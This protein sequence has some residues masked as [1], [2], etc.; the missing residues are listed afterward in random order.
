MNRKHSSYFHVRVSGGF[1][2]YWVYKSR[3]SLA[4]SLLI[5]PFSSTSKI[6]SEIFP[7]YFLRCSCGLSFPVCG[8][9]V[10]IYI[11]SIVEY[12]IY[13]YI[14][15]LTVPGSKNGLGDASVTALIHLP[16]H[17]LIIGKCWLQFPRDR[18]SF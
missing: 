15:Y 2:S 3:V 9:V 17:N 13:I 7:F 6:F 4:S 14:I 16:G 11:S 18:S 10:S 1:R 12:L 8:E 5:L